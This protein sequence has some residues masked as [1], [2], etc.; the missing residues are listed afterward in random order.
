[1]RRIPRLEKWK[2]PAGHP[3]TY[4]YIYLTPALWAKSGKSELG[5]VSKT[6][7]IKFAN[8]LQIWRLFH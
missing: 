5:I 7:E 6:R 3:Y 4:K 8:I 2:I 1:M